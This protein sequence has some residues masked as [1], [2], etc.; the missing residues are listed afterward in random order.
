[1]FG[2]DQSGL[3]GK[4]TDP[5]ATQTYNYL[6]ESVQL[7]RQ[8]YACVLD[9]LFQISSRDIEPEYVGIEF[10]PGWHFGIHKGVLK[11]LIA[12][13]DEASAAAF[14]QF[15]AD[16]GDGDRESTDNRSAGPDG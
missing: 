3:V 6:A 1:V 15:V 16:L 11:R 13:V 7:I 12:V 8:A 2:F 5:P 10:M 14:L 9:P 4:V